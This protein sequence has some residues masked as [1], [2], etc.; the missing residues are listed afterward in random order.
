V[1]RPLIATADVVAN[2]GC[3]PTGAILAL[4]PALRAGMVE[5]SG[6][7]VDSKTGVSGAGRVPKPASHYCEVNEGVRAYGVGSHRHAPEI[8]Q[9]L[10]LL[11]GRK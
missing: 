6:I 7:V 5:A 8:A 4:A 9:E 2:P 1:H 3:F 11:A 10:S